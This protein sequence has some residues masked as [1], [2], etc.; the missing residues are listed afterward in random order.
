MKKPTLIRLAMAC[1]IWLGTTV[2]LQAQCV[3]DTTAPNIPGV[4]PDSIPPLL[5]CNFGETDI[6]FVF[7]RDTT[8]TFAGQQITIPFQSFTITGIAGLPAG[9][10]WQC[11]LQPDCEYDV[12]PN[13]V[14]PDTVGCIRISGTPTIPGTY[15]LTVFLDV[16]LGPTFGTSQA[17][18]NAQISV[19]PCVFTGA[20]Y[21]Y[22]LSTNCAPA[23]F[24]VQNNINSLG[25]PGFSYQW[26]FTGPGLNYTTADE[27]PLPQTVAQSGTYILQYEAQVDTIGFLMDSIVVNSVNCGDAFGGAPD[28]YWILKDPVGQQLVNTSSSVLSNFNSFP[29]NIG[30]P[31]TLLDTGI[32]TLEVWDD[33][34]IGGD[35][36]CADG[37]NNASVTLNVP[38]QNTGAN[39]VTS[40]GLTVTF[41]LS[42]P[43]SVVSCADTFTLDSIPVAPQVM[44]LGDTTFCEG[45]SVELIV[46]TRDSVQWLRDGFP[47]PNANSISYMAKEGGRYGVEVI[48]STLCRNTSQLLELDV[49]AVPVPS[50]NVSGNE[51]EVAVFDTSQYTYT[52]LKDG[53]AVGTGT[54][55]VATQSGVYTVVAT[56]KDTGCEASSGSVTYT[57]TSLSEADFFD[58]F[59]VYP[60]PTQDRV[61]L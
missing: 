31:R 38:T 34:N 19:S 60:N 10:T 36:G 12:S 61:Y 4:Y 48:S 33:D 14:Q 56:D 44:L 23:Q 26:S 32:Y 57:A 51:F 11:N 28:I 59:E 52:W 29:L 21:T 27:N 54:Q 45:D 24:D 6:T 20:C 5:G 25:R 58:R 8:V 41:Y 7:P 37:N 40:G 15:P 46:S 2:G 18:Y 39:V 35:D 49:V 55:F 30:Y 9:M 17:S 13:A 1:M 43:I 47:I 22:S 53:V 3:I 42:N 50:L 16:D